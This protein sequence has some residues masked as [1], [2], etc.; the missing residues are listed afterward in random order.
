MGASAYSEKCL[1]PDA[2]RANQESEREC[3]A[4]P[5][6]LVPANDQLMISLFDHSRDC[7]KIL[8][9]NGS[10]DF[11]HCGTIDALDQ[12]RFDGVR[13][14]IWWSLWPEHA[15]GA[16][17]AAFEKARAGKETEFLA[18]CPTVQGNMRRW[19]V[20][21]KPMLTDDGCI[22]GVVCTSR[23]IAAD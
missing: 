19:I 13:G 9:L 5:K 21:L 18:E 15:Q 8:G 20:C 11:M 22:A 23:D 17:K 3:R 7:V 14:Q 16:V 4:A 2:A 10:L 12:S 6:Q 1:S